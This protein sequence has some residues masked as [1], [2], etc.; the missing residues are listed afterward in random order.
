MNRFSLAKILVI[1]ILLL[2]AVSPAGCARTPLAPVLNESVPRFTDDLDLDSLKKAVRINL[3]YLHH[4]PPGRTISV[5]DQTFPL[6][7]LIRSLEYFQ[8][9]LVGN[10]SPAEL[11]RL[12]RQ[13]YDI[14]QA[15]GAK[16]SN[17]GRRMLVTGYFQPVFEGR[18]SKQE[19]FLYP[20]FAVPED[21]IRANNRNGGD[22]SLGRL[23][24]G[25][26]V[27]YWTRKEIE[28]DNRA[29]GH[30]LAWLKDPFDAFVLH[31]QGS[32]LIRLE[33]GTVKG[34]HFAG[35]NGH[36]YRSIGKYLVETG[37]MP[38]EKASLNTIRDYINSH[39]EE[40]GEILH[41][42]PSFIFFDW[43][44]THGAM[45]NLGRELT[46]GR[47]IAAD[48]SCFPAGGLAFLRTRKPT[49]INNQQVAWSELGRFVL[50]QDTGSA[51]RG[52]GR[53]D[54]FWGTGSEAGFAAGQMKEQGT[55]YFF[56]LKNESLPQTAQD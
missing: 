27:P 12:I 22:Q 44:K 51:I 6:N 4:Q 52:P 54:L 35:K 46:P 53:I 5:A 43:T 32:G 49:R 37:R 38:L 56:L 17:P 47:S 7:R 13:H 34:V 31:I 29:S 19:P 1:L 23:E 45:G 15:T 2:T 16:G 25:S 42:N 48:Q 30:E 3:E 41:H 18:L 9:I 8:H 50:V 36:P 40:R 24:N 55:L 14:Y 33:D 39:P 26:L 28:R 11:D 20:L 10:P 21:L